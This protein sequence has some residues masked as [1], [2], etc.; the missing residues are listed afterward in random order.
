MYTLLTRNRIEAIDCEFQ[1]FRHEPTGARI[2]HLHTKRPL[3]AFQLAFR[4]LPEDHSGV[5]HILEHSVLQGSR[6]LPQPGVYSKR[7]TTAIGACQASTG[8]DAT[9]Y[10][11]NS[12]NRIDF[13][14]LLDLYLDAAFFPLL[15]EE[16]FQQ[17][18]HHLEWAD[19]TDHSLG[20]KV[21]G[22][23]YNEMKGAFS[24]PLRRFQQ[25]LTRAA[26]PGTVYAQESGGD[27][28]AIRELEYEDFLAF[29]RRFYCPANA[30][31]SYCGPLEPGELLARFEDQVFSRWTDGGHAALPG[32]DR[33]TTV[34][35]GHV[36][37]GYP[38]RDPG[39]ANGC[40]TARVWNL[41]EAK[42]ADERLAM[43]FR[44]KALLLNPVS[45]I[46]QMLVESG[47]GS[48]LV[49]RL[50]SI[51]RPSIGMFQVDAGRMDEVH[52][53][54]DGE[55]RRLAEHGLSRERLEAVYLQLERELAETEDGGPL[56]EFPMQ[57]LKGIQ[58]DIWL[59]RDPQ[60]GLNPV[61]RLRARKNTLLDE[62]QFRQW[63]R[64][65]FL[66]NPACIRVDMLPDASMQ[67]CEAEAERQ[68][69]ERKLAELGDQTES[70]LGGIEQRITA[71]RSDN[72]RDHEIPRLTRRDLE[73]LPA[74]PLPREHRLGQHVLHAYPAATNGL[75]YL[76]L[77]LELPRM[78][79]DEAF[80]LSLLG[81]APQLGFGT[82][83]HPAAMQQRQLL[84]SAFDVDM[85]IDMDVNDVSAFSCRLGLQ[86]Y[87]RA[88]D[89][90]AWSPMMLQSL[91]DLRLD[92]R[93]RWR[94][95]LQVQHGS[96]KLLL[97]QRELPRTLVGTL[98]SAL[99]PHAGLQ[100]HCS[101]LER[102]LREAGLLHS[103]ERLDTEL[104]RLARWLTDL[105][106]APHRYTL[107]ADRAEELSG[108]LAPN[109]TV[110]KRLPTSGFAHEVIE[111]R[112]VLFNTTVSYCG[113]ALPGLPAAHPD[114][115]L[116]Q[117]AA[118]LIKN[119]YLR[120]RLREQKGAYGGVAINGH[121][122][123]VMYSS[124]D[125]RILGSLE[126]MEGA[127]HWLCAVTADDSRVE[128]AAIAILSQ[129]L[130]SASPV[131]AIREQE[132]RLRSGH[133][134]ELEER[135]FA[136]LKRATHRDVIR[137]VEEHLVPR[138]ANGVRCVFTS[139]ALAR[140]ERLNGWTEVRID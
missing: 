37:G 9:F 13:L 115:C 62:Q 55:L 107:V 36:T 43:D 11:F 98:K 48:P 120:P 67:A 82:L 121:G 26:L 66:D 58:E 20:L 130:K 38:A 133:T 4:T 103:P 94:N 25:L 1:E 137:A 85:L 125:P 77:D 119:H 28:A 57:L 63:V 15:A 129:S 106:G 100:G 2:V 87:C 91:L 65:G 61:E 75:A 60:E 78:S 132:Q 102:Y 68:Y 108:S 70:L 41:V 96:R 126:D 32:E 19:P 14:Q 101:G 35:L 72:S 59:G 8:K 29:H 40:F 111:R 31:F 52:A 99:L 138:M 24:Q 105:S 27:P 79:A 42:D 124:R 10:H 136:L 23:V 131:A 54:V 113:L 118:T 30:L 44:L 84:A 39:A 50:F 3:H 122:L 135:D 117:L 22:V 95:L 140:K 6:N 109:G 16:V 93:E 81:L 56:K 83:D 110:G 46:V 134:R 33:F 18:G 127:L 7:V 90:P 139:E 17:E 128:Q 112:V 123:F 97:F 116:L 89:L 88:E 5:A 49:F 104:A 34:A 74:P 69:L 12:A 73:L 21:V 92:T 76:D 71:R 47:L 53:L 45:P 51:S 64:D 86:S 114:F 80:G